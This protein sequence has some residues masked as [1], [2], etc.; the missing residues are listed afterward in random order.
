MTELV[1]LPRELDAEGNPKSY[2]TPGVHHDRPGEPRLQRL[3]G[4]ASW[5]ERV[6]RTLNQLHI[7]YGMQGGL[8]VEA[9][10]LMREPFD[11]HAMKDAGPLA[12]LLATTVERVLSIRAVA[13]ARRDARGERA[14]RA[15]I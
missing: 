13:F 4:R 5:E 3:N 10:H 12:L 2:E 6:Y 11:K 15:C 14:P 7:Y 1:G 9:K 8:A